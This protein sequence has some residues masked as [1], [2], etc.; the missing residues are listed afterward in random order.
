MKAPLVVMVSLDDELPNM[1]REFVGE[2]RWLFAELK[3]ITGLS[4]RVEHTRPV[5]VFVQID[6]EADIEVPYRAISELARS[7]SDVPVVVISDAKL[8]D[9]DRPT[10]TTTLLNLGAKHIIFP[11]FT[12]LV[13]EDL[14][15]GLMTATIIRL[16][17]K[18]P[19][20]LPPAPDAIDLAEG[21]YEDE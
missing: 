19:E 5:V 15:G 12:K 10:W 4:A 16:T 14:A 20:P 6:P 17:G 1:I 18:P 2:Q 21:G 11:P 13:L 3:Q 9:D 7:H 8:H